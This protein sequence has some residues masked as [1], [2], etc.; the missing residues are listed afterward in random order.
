VPLL[1]CPAV[2]IAGSSFLCVSVPLWF[3]LNG[4]KSK[5]E[6]QHVNVKIFVDGELT[7]DMERFIETFHK[8]VAEQTMDGEMMIDVADYRHVPSG[9]GVV[10]VGLEADYSLDNT[11]GRRGLRYNRK[12]PVEGS[13][14]DRLRR[15]FA[16]A[17]GACRRLEEEYGD[18]KFSRR[19][20]ELFINDRALAPNT[21][22]TFESAKPDLEAFLK[23][24]VGNDFTIEHNADLRRLFGATVRLE[25][26]FD[27]ASFATS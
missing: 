6:L 18:L 11:G 3:S 26:P 21:A 8:W 17:A 25:Q 9:P 15:A 12:G 24:S 1:A 10:M 13:N 2:P 4:K 14:A 7:V 23:E 16:A 22:E 27:L 5:M 20:F 19:E